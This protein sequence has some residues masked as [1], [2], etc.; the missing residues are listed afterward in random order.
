MD[1]VDFSSG[2]RMNEDMFRIVEEIDCK[3][4]RLLEILA[5][6]D[7]KLAADLSAHRADTESHRNAWQVRES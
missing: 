5:N 4:D 3:V 6:I 1:A 7:R 2:K